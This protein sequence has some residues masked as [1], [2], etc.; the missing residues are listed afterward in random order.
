[1]NCYSGARQCNSLWFAFKVTNYLKIGSLKQ[2]L[3]GKNTLDIGITGPVKANKFG[4][5]H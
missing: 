5:G 3:R 1:M 4:L 2:I